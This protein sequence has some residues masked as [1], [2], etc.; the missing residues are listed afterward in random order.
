MTTACAPAARGPYHCPSR[1]EILSSLLV[2]LPRGRAWQT[3]DGGPDPVVE[4]AFQ[5][6]AFQSL[7]FQT[8]QRP[9][10]ILW[11]YWRAVADVLA[12][13]TQRWCDLR[14]EF[15]CATHIETHDLWMREYGLPNPCDP[16]PDLCAKVA[17]VGGTRCE[18]YAEIAARAG[19]SLTCADKIVD[20]GAGVGCFE[21][22]CDEVGGAMPAAT[23]V[24]IVN[25]NESPAYTV[26]LNN[27]S[28]AGCMEAGDGLDCAPDIR[29]LKCILDHVVHAHLVIEY[30]TI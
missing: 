3:D 10:S 29:P 9:G 6:A 24:V 15:W 5:G 26:P 11:R 20:C 17:A 23:L 16:F 1:D 21:T 12:Y 18:Y 8:M 22:G 4:G 28:Q 30:Q 27:A 7:A 2:E 19:W 13:A 14:E 25:L